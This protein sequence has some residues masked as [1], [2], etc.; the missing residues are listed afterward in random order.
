MKTKS[1]LLFV[2]VLMFSVGLSSCK[3]DDSS[4]LKVGLVT[5]L[6]GLNDGGFNDQAFV[7]L[8]AANNAESIRW[9]VKESYDEAQ[10]ASNIK[11]FTDNKFDVIITLGYNASQSTLEAA[12]AFP[13]IKFIIL[14]YSFETIPDNITCITYKVD[15]AS[16]P[17]GF[18]AA[19]QAWQKNQS[20][21]AVGYVAGPNIPEIQQFTVSFAKGVEFFNTKYNQSVTVSGANAT[22]FN[23]TLQGARIADSLIQRGAEVIFAC[24]GKTGNGALYKVKEASK[25]GIGVDTDQFYSIPLV[26]P[27]LLTSC[28]KRLD[29]AIL[30]E[31]TSIHNG[32]FHGGQVFSFDLAN[33]GVNVA[34]YHNYETMLPDSIKQSVLD[35]KTGIIN[36]TILTGWTK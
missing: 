15:Q 29:V 24:A 20:N 5:G 34:P 9:E 11:Y 21:P 18:L 28:M 7:G 32:Q 30:S 27:Y 6:G 19:Y 10:I 22:N 35:I 14:D 2:L 13:K 16:F 12:E 36:G 8:M 17:C 23:D 31:I 25:T 4:S 1:L 26:G 3:K 33:E